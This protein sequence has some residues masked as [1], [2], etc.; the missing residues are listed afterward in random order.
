MDRRQFIGSSA[1]AALS[2][3]LAGGR[4]AMAASAPGGRLLP[5]ALNR[6]DTIGLVS[7]SSATDERMDL[8][9]AQD[10]MQAL[11]FE[12]RTGGHYAS[13]YGHLAGTDAGRAGDINAMFADDG[14]K[15]VIC[16]RGG[17]GAARLLP[18]LDY[19]VIRANPKVLLGFSDITALHC[20]IHAR[21]GLVTFHGPNGGSSWN[22]FNADQ[23]QRLFFDRELMEYRNAAEAG[24]ELVP[25]RNRT[26]TIAGGKVRGELVG[27]NL[28]V[29]SALAGSPYLP[30]FAGRI[31]F[32]EDV[33]EAPYRIDR[34]L[35]TLKLMGALDAIAGFIFGEC[36][37]CDPGE[38]YGSLTLDQIF[39]DHIK[40]LGIPAY[41]G[42]MIGHV[43][44]QF[45]VPVGGR[46]ELDADQG[47]FRLLEPVFQRG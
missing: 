23:F 1:L 32:L 29:L 16:L 22:S 18:L 7:P 9:L 2:L 39:D 37:D 11:G 35:T 26:L 36:T 17:S 14:V 31:L 43:R 10:T 40:P 13:R 33:S 20:A 46:V 42:A 5:V 30:D 19:D 44:E 27:G 8:Q 15:A 6:G 12:V 28:A 24:D 41:R 25:R 34:M 45:I 47:S 21:T 3:P 38:G 4:G